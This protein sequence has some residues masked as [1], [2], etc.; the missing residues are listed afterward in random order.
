M[1]NRQQA[2]YW[3]ELIALKV[4]CEYVRLY[5][6][7]LGRW[8]TRFAVLRAIASSGAI[9]TW[10]VVKSYPLVW[11]GIIAASQVA[12]ALQ[13]AIPLAARFRGTNTLCATFDALFID[14]QVEWEDIFAGRLD[15]VE[16]NKR[17]HKLMK[18]REDADAKNLPNGLPDRKDFLKLAEDK[19]AAYFK[20]T[21]PNEVP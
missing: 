14:C 17:R 3:N 16:I 15:D 12:D 13:S 4:G 7:D 20:N 8:M 18:L 21:Y 6:S 11:G 10:A 19:A 9:A 2:L 5:R 1:E